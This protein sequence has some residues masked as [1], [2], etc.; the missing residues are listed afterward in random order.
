MD[1][2]NQKYRQES[3]FSCR[4]LEDDTDYVTLPCL[5]VEQG[6][7]EGACQR[8]MFGRHLTLGLSTL[9]SGLWPL[10]LQPEVMQ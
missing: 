2:L 10:D 8:P 6:E 5:S 3:S 7:P 4:T 9:A 1:Y